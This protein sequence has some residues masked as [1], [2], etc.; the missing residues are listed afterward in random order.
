MRARYFV[1]ACGGIE[2]ARILL[3]SNRVAR[4]GLGNQYDRVGRFFM[5]HPMVQRSARVFTR[6]PVRIKALFEPIEKEDQRALAGLCPTPL[7]QRTRRILNCSATFTRAPDP[8]AGT[9]RDAWPAD[10]EKER[11]TLMADLD[12]GRLQQGAFFN[13]TTRSE[14]APNPDSR[15]TL[16]HERDALGLNKVLLDWRLTELDFQTIRISL[17]LIGEELGRLGLGHVQLADWLTT[18]QVNWPDSLNW[19]S[20][21]MGT[22]RMADNP[23][24]GVV[25]RNCRLHSVTNLYIAGS[26]VFTTSGYMNP[27]LTIVALALRLADH[28]KGQFPA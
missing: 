21:H 4:A 25:D 13:L 28:L 12:D 27:T 15:I 8:R 11:I 18:N 26:S 1:L 23:K 9:D 20:H 6:E 10:L 22:T 3:L 19:G 2:N 5:D 7:S 24:E 16:S 14:Q 17:E